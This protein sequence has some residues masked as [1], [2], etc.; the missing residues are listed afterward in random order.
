LLVGNRLSVLLCPDAHLPSAA[1]TEITFPF[2][3][4]A[5]LVG[6]I[7]HGFH[8]GHSHGWHRRHIKGYGHI[9]SGDWFPVLSRQLHVHDVAAFMRRLGFCRQLHARLLLRRSIHGSRLTGTGWRR[10]K[11]SSSRLQ[12]R[13]GIDQEICGCDNLFVSLEAFTDHDLIADLWHVLY[14]EWF[15]YAFTM[16]VKLVVLVSGD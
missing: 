10:N 4:A 14:F 8:R 11:R 6:S 3:H 1:G 12:L 5:A 16:I 2:I 13:F 9:R 15:D 7:D